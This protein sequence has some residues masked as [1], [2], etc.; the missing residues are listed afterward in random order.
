[1]TMYLITKAMNM[2]ALAYQEKIIKNTKWHDR[3]VNKYV[4][5][6]QFT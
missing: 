1:M 6:F 4:V 2:T 3:F 5:V